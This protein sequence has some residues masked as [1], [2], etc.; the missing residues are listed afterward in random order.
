MD[1]Q[2]AP[3]LP[4]SPGLR[5]SALAD[6][7]AATVTG[8]DDPV[9]ADVTHDHRQ[10][11]PGSLFCCIV[12]T[13]HDGHDHAGEAVAQ[14]A[15]ALLCERPLGIGVPEIIV[16]DAR[17]AAG[18][19]AAAAWGNPSRQL[20]VVGVTGTNGKTTVVTLVAQLLT[21]LGVSA[22]VIGTLTNVRTTPE[23]TDLQRT[24]AS[25]VDNG[26]AVVAM[27]VSSHAL[28]LGRV[29]GTHFEVA[30]FT[31]LGTDHLDFHETPERYFDAKAAL[32]E[33]GRCDVAVI[34]IDDVHG[35]LLSQTIAHAAA[36]ELVRVSADASDIQLS[37][38]GTRFSWHGTTVQLP[39]RGRFNVT[40]ALI[41]AEILVALGH[42]PLAVA[43]A[44][45]GVV[46]PAGRF[47]SVDRGQ[48]FAVLVDFAH[49]PDALDV[50]L[51][52]ASELTGPDGRL[53]VV[54]GA[55]GDRDRSKRPQMGEVVSRNAD[56]VIVTSDNP[57][58]ELPSTIMAAVAEGCREVEP[59][60]I[61]DRREAIAAA[62]DAAGSGDVIVIAGKG[63][64]TTQTIGDRV[65]PFDDRLVAA[66]LLEAILP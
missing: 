22:E 30:A 33:P 32:F 28:V 35:R 49:T 25:M 62:I 29:N 57:R 36:P 11:R 46:A 45:T 50:M 14:G 54:F 41:A 38:T 4:S 10:V 21:A 13:T 3:I 5:L 9:V 58:S 26:T 15:V 51:D 61:E 31:N 39:L 34:N 47:E 24:L 40:N 63:H 48:D 64:E 66:E 16:D 7:I 56:V 8:D 17:A 27:E 60:L 2:P 59:I 23:S 53:I 55:G 19:L 12:G 44:L 65:E 1:E 20:T 52:A 42:P 43:S 37:P 18:S 6:A